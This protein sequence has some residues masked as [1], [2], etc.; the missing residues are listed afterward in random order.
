MNNADGFAAKLTS[1]V[2]NVF[3]GC[4]AYSNIDDG[5]DLFTKI[6]SGPIG[7]V[8]IEDCI[9]FRN[10]SLSD[11]SGNGDGNGFK[12][13]G[14]GIA[15][16]HVLRD[17]VAYANGA[18]GITSNSNPAIILENNI[19]YGNA[20]YNLA[21]YGKGDEARMFQVRGIISLDGVAPDN[22]KEMPELAAPYN[23]FWNG[24]ASINSLG[25]KLDASIF[26]HVD[27]KK[28]P[29]RHPDGSIDRGG[30]FTLVPGTNLTHKNP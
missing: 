23:Y 24:A 25:Q 8:V 3:R 7:A 13:G 15:V 30:L 26:E 16:P 9:A 29:S 1:G 20:N 6:E 17:S 19:V 12:L 22:I 18:S 27:I 5:W 4:I 21:L 28:M 2:G 11:G 14:D 10:G